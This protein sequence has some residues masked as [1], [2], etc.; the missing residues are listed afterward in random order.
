[1]KTAF[2]L[3]LIL[4][5]PAVAWA[6]VPLP[7]WATPVHNEM[8]DIAFPS[9]DWSCMAQLKAG[10]RNAD[11]GPYQTGEYSYMHAMRQK[12]QSPQ[13]A[14]AKMW[15]YVDDKYAEVRLLLKD[16]RKDDACFSRGMALHPIMDSTS[17][18]HR[19]FQEWDPIGWP[20]LL[21]PGV[22]AGKLADMAHHGD[23]QKYLDRLV[24]L[25]FNLS[26]E[27]LNVIDDHP[28]FLQI[29]A[30]LM[31]AVETVELLG[32]DGS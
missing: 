32:A 4:I 31:H 26:D 3:C 7:P 21:S 8:L 1:M 23:F 17:P 25:P 18:A 15:S 30:D 27:D 10:S 5:S 24:Q 20:D 22:F 13:A 12:G 19:G 6:A 28:E 2:T 29:T 14:A 9:E 16:G 11:S